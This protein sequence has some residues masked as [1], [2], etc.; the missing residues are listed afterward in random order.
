MVGIYVYHLK[1][2][3]HVVT[4]NLG[5]GNFH[6]YKLCTESETMLIIL[7]RIISDSHKMRPDSA[8]IIHQFSLINY[9]LRFIF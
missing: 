8:N 2:R 6:F 4:P 5:V 1:L 9:N 3:R 7:Y